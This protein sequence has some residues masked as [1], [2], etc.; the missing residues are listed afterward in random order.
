MQL[1]FF[2]K[3]YEKTT[4]VGMHASAC[5][6][7]MQSRASLSAPEL[8]KQQYQGWVYV[9]NLF[10]DTKYTL[11]EFNLLLSTPTI[12]IWRALLLSSIT[13]TNEISLYLWLNLH[14][15]E[16]KFLVPD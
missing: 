11:I 5:A 14:S 2:P 15:A 16:A 3:S 1:L 13:I 10:V 4:E 6:L 12:S 9:F 8:K 7:L